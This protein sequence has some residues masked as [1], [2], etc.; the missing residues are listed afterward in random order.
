MCSFHPLVLGCCSATVA[1]FG[2]SQTNCLL[3]CLYLH[4]KRRTVSLCIQLDCFIFKRKARLLN[5]FVCFDVG[6]NKSHVTDTA[7]K[8][9]FTPLLPIAMIEKGKISN[10]H[11]AISSILITTP[12]LPH[13]VKMAQASRVPKWSLQLGLFLFCLF[14]RLAYSC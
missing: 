6:R 3:W 4:L 13:H 7:R 10:Q 5:L 1:V 2:T 11:A 12:S 14:S 9:I 8:E